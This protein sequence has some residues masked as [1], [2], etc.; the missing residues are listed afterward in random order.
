MQRCKHILILA[1]VALTMLLTCTAQAATSNNVSAFNVIAKIAIDRSQ[2]DEHALV[3]EIAEAIKGEFANYNYNHL[4]PISAEENMEGLDVVDIVHF[5][6]VNIQG[7]TE[8]AAL[9]ELWS[10]RDNYYLERLSPKYGVNAPWAISVYTISAASLQMLSVAHPELNPAGSEDQFT[11]YIVVSAINPL[12][13]S[14]VGYTDLPRFHNLMFNAHCARVKSEI[15]AGV[16]NALCYDTDLD[17]DMASKFFSRW[18]W[19]APAFDVNDLLAGVDITNSDVA[20]LPQDV[21]MPSVTIPGASA[22]D[23]AAALKGY[24]RATMPMYKSGGPLA[25]FNGLVREFMGDLFSWSGQAPFDKSYENPMYDPSNPATGEPLMDI[26]FEDVADMK[27]QVPT[28]LNMMFVPM[29]TGQNP[30][31]M[32]LMTQGWKFPRAFALGNN[33]EVQIIELCTMFYA[34]MALGTGMHHTPA[35]PC[36][37]AVYQDGDDAVAQMFTAKATFS[38][39]FKD[40]V[41]AMDTMNMEAQTYLFA[42][43]PEVIY[44]DVA[45]MYNGAFQ[46]AGI[47]ARFEIRPF[48]N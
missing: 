32:P 16:S 8:Y 44:N 19:K 4:K 15:K 43:F 40:S 39:F 42:I 46:Q 22:T 3:E 25:N 47:D 30:A 36:M 13:V 27:A 1:T 7:S 20:G 11:D 14:K 21:T 38:A 18:W 37:A 48:T 31:R 29:W 17:W 2:V 24:M 6:A 34:Q 35:M 28:L 23:V 5:P 9:V 26:Y 41:I 33:D 45:A 10:P 12:A